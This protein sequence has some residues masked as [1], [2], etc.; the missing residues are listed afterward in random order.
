VQPKVFANHPPGPLPGDT[1]LD[2]A[3]KFTN[4]MMAYPQ[5]L[6]LLRE[7][8]TP[9]SRSDWTPDNLVV[10][11]SLDIS[12]AVSGRVD[13]SAQ[14]LGRVNSRGEWQPPSPSAAPPDVLLRLRQV[15]GQWRVANA[16]R[17]LY[18]STDSFTRDYRQ[19][20][21]YFFNAAS[22]ILTQDPVY[23]LLRPGVG[24]TATALVRDLL[25]GP[26]GSMHGVAH[27][28]AP[29][30]VHAER[31]DVSPNGFADVR[32]S[33]PLATLSAHSLRL[34][35]AQLAWTLDQQP[36]GITGITIWL[37]GRPFAVPDVP[38]P[39]SAASSALLSY[40]NPS[41]LN[42]QSQ[43]YAL[44]K[45]RLVQVPTTSEAPVKPS[46]E[47]GS[48]RAVQPVGS[49]AVAVNASVAALVVAG[50]TRVVVGEV[51]AQ[52][53]VWSSPRHFHDLLK[54]SWDRNGLL[55]VIDRTA[56]NGAELYVRKA[57]FGSHFHAVQ[58]PGITGQPVR[59]FA[60]SSDGTR[61]AAIV[62]TRASSQVVVA[63]IRSDVRPELDISITPARRVVS[64]T[65]RFDDLK[66]LA[67]ASPTDLALLA[68]LP[69][70][71]ETE[72][73]EMSIDGSRVVPLNSALPEA[74]LTSLAAESGVSPVIGTTDG[75]LFVLTPEQQWAPIRVTDGALD[76]PTYPG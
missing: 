51:S 74:P 56:D 35:A 62:G 72:P 66:A 21:L 64:A 26:T 34:F 37:D 24:R 54:P 15:H 52:G 16:P 3:I 1:K 32:L 7:F 53:P 50:G 17:T 22:S 46:R 71:T 5:S 11:Q 68:S 36:L 28:V 58:A 6:S 14:E 12:P 44:S 63:M 59:A 8:L 30:G 25:Q 29:S 69:G 23:E 76:A 13:L 42:P 49:V 55:W 43:L 45:G 31:V 33:G 20:S 18:V 48:I 9:A 47:G 60:V 40:Y 39:F 61:L 67:W 27:L 4:A 2:T 19:F 10:Y 41:G 65:S 38:A 73:F 57:S 75:G 70:S